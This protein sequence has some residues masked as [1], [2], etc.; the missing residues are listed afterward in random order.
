MVKKFNIEEQ[1]QLLNGLNQKLLDP[2]EIKDQKLHKEFRFKNFARAFGFMT[3]VAIC[4]EKSD[5]HPEWFNVYNKVDI[6]LTTH[7]F[8]GITQR[9]FDLANKIEQLL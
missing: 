7:E 2:W 5:H 8:N 1:Q 4:A 9:D 6:Y 3:S